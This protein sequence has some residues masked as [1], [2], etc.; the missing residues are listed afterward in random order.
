MKTSKALYF[1]QL[2]KLRKIKNTLYN[3]RCKA[4]E[5]EQERLNSARWWGDAN[6]TEQY[7][8]ENIDTLKGELKN[9]INDL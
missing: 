3:I 2:E 6:Q 9:L 7:F 8:D 4:S 1:T 5:L